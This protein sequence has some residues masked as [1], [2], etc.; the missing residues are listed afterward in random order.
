MR[1][2]LAVLPDAGVFAV[3]AVWLFHA[4]TSQPPL[5][6]MVV[7][8]HR[9]QRPLDSVQRRRSDRLP[10][11]L[12]SRSP[13]VSRCRTAAASVQPKRQRF[14]DRFAATASQPCSRAQ[15]HQLDHLSRPVL[16]ARAA[17][18]ALAR[19]VVD[20]PA[21]G[22][23]RATAPAARS[24]QRARLSAPAHPGSAPG[25]E[26]ADRGR[27]SA[28]AA[29]HAPRRARPRHAPACRL[30]LHLRAGPQR[31]RIA[32]GLHLHAALAVHHAG[33]WHL[34]QVEAVLGQR[35]EVL[36][37]DRHRL[38][39]GSCSPPID[40]TLLVSPG[41]RPAAAR[42]ARPDRLPAGTGTQWLRRK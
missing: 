19:T 9:R 12:R 23:A 42:S 26:S 21:S 11:V 13:A 25:R 24:G 40:P 39:D 16:L 28:R 14:L 15:L 17:P 31:H 5:S 2:R 20:S 3:P 38:A 32:V 22:P 4:C 1:T 34:G 33:S 27:S 8:R 37:L 7:V 30:G 29:R 41:S 6:S 10:L 36:P 35:Q 18:S